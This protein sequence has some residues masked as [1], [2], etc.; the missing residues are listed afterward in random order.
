MFR[1]MEMIT[2]ETKYPDCDR[3]TEYM[4]YRSGDEIAALPF[5]SV[6]ISYELVIPSRG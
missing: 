3:F 6:I 2:E 1:V 5:F 4:V